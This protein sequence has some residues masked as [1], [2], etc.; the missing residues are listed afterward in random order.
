MITSLWWISNG[1]LSFFVH[2]DLVV[3]GK[4]MLLYIYFSWLFSSHVSFFVFITLYCFLISINEVMGY[5]I[6]F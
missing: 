1:L 6:L 2:V 4:N 5:V 3:L